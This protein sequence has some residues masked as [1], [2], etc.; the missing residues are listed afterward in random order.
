MSFISLYGLNV[1]SNEVTVL[2]LYESMACFGLLEYG[3]AFWSQ[4]K[5]LPLKHVS[6]SFPIF[7]EAQI[8]EKYVIPKL[9]P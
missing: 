7:L 6:Q 1:L 3:Y 4:I 2:D 5:E 9:P 8:V